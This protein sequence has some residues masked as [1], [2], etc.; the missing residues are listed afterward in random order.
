VG[1]LAIA[2]V[3][4]VL[5]AACGGAAGWF[6]SRS[7]ARSDRAWEI[8]YAV[9]EVQ[10]QI[11][12]A[13]TPKTVKTEADVEKLWHDWQTAHRRFYILGQEKAAAPLTKVIDSYLDSLK[14]FVRQELTPANL[15]DQRQYT[16]DRVTEIMKEFAKG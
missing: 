2:I 7:Q 14:Q 16:R 11:L 6:T 5:G 8:A 9:S 15:E 3:S 1:D 10:A 4:A 13:S 12:S